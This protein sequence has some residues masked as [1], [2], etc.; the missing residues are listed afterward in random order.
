MGLRE[1]CVEDYF[2]EG[3]VLFGREEQRQ[4]VLK[5]IVEIF[6]RYTVRTDRVLGGTFR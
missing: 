2:L 1:V 5:V 4:S 6:L 3:V